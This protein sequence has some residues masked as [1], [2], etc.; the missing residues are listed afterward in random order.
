MMF[1][2]VWKLLSKS[3][4]RTNHGDH[5]AGVQTSSPSYQGSYQGLLSPNRLS[6]N[7][8]RRNT[9]P[10]P[11]STRVL[12]LMGGKTAIKYSPQHVFHACANVDDAI[13]KDVCTLQEPPKLHCTTIDEGLIFPPPHEPP[14]TST[15]H[16]STNT[17]NVKHRTKEQVAMQCTSI[18]NKN[19]LKMPTGMPMGPCQTVEELYD[20]IN[21]WAKYPSTDG[22]GS[23][24][25]KK[26]STKGPTKFR[27]PSKLIL[28]SRGGPIRAKVND[29]RVAKQHSTI[30]ECPWE[31][32]TEETT[33]GWVVSVPTERAIRFAVA[34]GKE[35]KECLCHNHDLVKTDEERLVFPTMR[36]IPPQIETFANNLHE[37][38]CLT[39]SQLYHALVTK[40][41]KEGIPQTFTQSDI[42]NKYRTTLSDDILD[43]SN[44]AE[45]L[46]E[47]QAHNNELDYAIVL[48][49]DGNLERV[50]F[51][52]KEGKAIWNQSMGAILLYD[53]KHGTNKYGLKLGCFVSVDRRGITR[54]LA[55]SFV[56]KEDEESFTWAYKMF[57]NSFQSAPVVLYTDSDAA[58]AAATKAAWPET[59][60]LLCTFHLWKN[61]WQH[62]R[63]LFVGKEDMWRTVSDMWWRLCKTTDETECMHF[64]DKFNILIQLV[65]DNA[66]TLSGDKL[67]TELTWMRSLCLR[68]E[69][70]AA[71]FTWKHRTYGIHSTQRAEAV[72]SA[73]NNFCSTTNTILA[74]TEKLEQMAD[75]H[76]LKDRMESIN[77]L[78][79]GVIGQKPIPLPA[80]ERIASSLSI[81]PRV[82]LNAQAALVLQYQCVPS[83]NCDEV[84]LPEDEKYY[85]V[86]HANAGGELASHSLLRKKSECT[87]SDYADFNKEV[88]HGV[89]SNLGVIKSNGH[90]T[91]L[92]RCSCQYPMVMGLPCRH[93]LRVMLQLSG[94]VLQGVHSWEQYLV[95]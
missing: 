74:I 21:H 51:V 66:N 71:C 83:N 93:M 89:P 26:N 67:E 24:S 17:T 4:P 35:G 47:R 68:K 50:F 7:P 86:V 53:T 55:G 42:K 45:H 78:L 22:D 60:H 62:L 41:R 69:Q 63:K 27:G 12:G 73:I 40:C 56:K 72:H 46:K 8:K 10:S 87:L 88:D 13:D 36:E 94:T 5:A 23:F 18:L 37:A 82:L 11:G 19:G 30:T 85:L 59:I 79:R 61:F 6:P 3:P 34:E 14:S 75:E 70:W 33:E 43:C 65:K 38:G 54:V 32:W 31:V 39:P 48:N 20:Q 58:M 95:C 77:V 29:T 52:L 2:S 44:L 80:L 25:V 28:C 9:N 49:V 64:D 81:F 15:N 84:N 57:H 76:S 92:K 90:Q 1:N 16:T 91:S